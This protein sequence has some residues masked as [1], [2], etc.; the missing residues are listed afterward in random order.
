M[1][2]GW[3]SKKKFPHC[4]VC[5]QRRKMMGYLIVGVLCLLV[6]FGGGVYVY[7]T[8]AA[9]LIA[10]AQAAAAAAAAKLSGK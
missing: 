6:G 2:H 5:A 10:E 3:P 9:K 1:K 7:K 4:A 8:Y